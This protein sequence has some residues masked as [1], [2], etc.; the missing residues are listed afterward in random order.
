MCK[1]TLTERQ[2]KHRPSEGTRNRTERHANAAASTAQ[3]TEPQGNTD[4]ASGRGTETQANTTHAVNCLFFVLVRGP[5]EGEGGFRENWTQPAQLQ[6]PNE[7]RHRRGT[8]NRW[9]Y[10]AYDTYGLSEDPHPMRKNRKETRPSDEQPRHNAKPRSNRN[11]PPRPVCFF[12][13][14][15]ETYLTPNYFKD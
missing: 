8:A 13:T 14:M 1:A 12:E 3:R 6:T 11:R 7:T 2:A 4:P 10:Q 9:E 15:R 5:G